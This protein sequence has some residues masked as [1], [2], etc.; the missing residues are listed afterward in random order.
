MAST[1]TSRMAQAFD[2]LSGD[3]DDAH[4]DAVAAELTRWLDPSAGRAVA[5]AACGTGAVALAVAGRWKG[6]GAASPVLAVDLSAGMVAAGRA[7]AERAGLAGAVDWRVGPAVPLP[8]R[9]GALDLVLCAS[10]LHFLGRAALADWLRA[11][12]PGGRVGFSLPVASTFRP[13]GVFAELVAADL[14]LPETAED[15]VRL[16][17]AAGFTAVAA[18]TFQV[19]TRAVLLV[20]AE[21]PG[22]E[23]GRAG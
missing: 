20:R 23:G 22:G 6:S 2:E 1:A 7:R 12:R 18:R 9:A 15:A 14:P 8:V 13:R 16:T 17:E 21:T 3:Y 19:G 5:D 10:S 11:L 4:H